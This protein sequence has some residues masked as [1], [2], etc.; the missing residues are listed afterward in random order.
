MFFPGKDRCVQ[1]CAIELD[2]DELDT[3][4]THNFEI[5][6]RP[7]SAG[8]KDLA[9]QCAI[10]LGCPANEVPCESFPM[11]I[12]S[13]WKILQT[14]SGLADRLSTCTANHRVLRFEGCDLP[15]S[16]KA[17]WQSG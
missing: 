17:Q 4:F 1:A 7:S 2:S 6:T 8:K 15:P 16:R 3:R 5:L 14:I 9:W 12:F 10:P 13:N 11:V